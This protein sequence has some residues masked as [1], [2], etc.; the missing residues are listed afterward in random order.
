MGTMTK[1][2]EEAVAQ[3]RELPEEEQ[4]E[5]AVTL[6]AHMRREEIDYE[7]T[8]EQGAGSPSCGVERPLRD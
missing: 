1:L 5:L 8:P 2:L 6:F 7:L 3:A 4:D